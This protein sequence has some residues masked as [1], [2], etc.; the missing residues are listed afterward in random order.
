[1]LLRVV[2]LKRH[3]C[4]CIHVFHRIGRCHP[5]HFSKSAS[6]SRDRH[7]RRGARTRR[8]GV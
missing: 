4:R 8:A 3:S 6:A 2:T 7:P 1:M 5:L